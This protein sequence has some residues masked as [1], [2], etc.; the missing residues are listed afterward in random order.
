MHFI[1]FRYGGVRQDPTEFYRDGE[2]R[3][4]ELVWPIAE[5]LDFNPPRGRILEIGCG[6]GR[7]FP[8]FRKLGFEEIWGTDV[9]P[10]MIRQGS[11]MCPVR[12]AHFTVGNGR[13]L[14]NFESNWFDYCFSYIVFQHI[15]DRQIVWSYLREMHRILRPG[16]GFQFQFRDK[17][18]LGERLEGLTPNALRTAAESVDAI[19]E[20]LRHREPSIDSGVPGSM[21][22]WYGPPLNPDE[23][24]SRLVR[25]G[26][27]AVDVIPDATHPNG[28]SS[29]AIG[30]KQY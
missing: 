7:L 12:E 1:T 27:T 26:F 30:R 10:E 23:V 25:L 18:S 5:R 14:G 28:L 3:G 15:P 9:S 11:E 6:I 4:V 29:W 22:T 20:K 21:R 13:D 19:L 24:R 16:G 17:R 2:R 8:G